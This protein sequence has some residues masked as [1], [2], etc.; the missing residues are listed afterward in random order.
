MTFTSAHVTISLD[1]FMAGPDQTLDDPLGR[2]GEALQV[3]GL[4]RGD[5]I[6]GGQL[7]DR[8]GPRPPVER[9]GPG[10]GRHAG[11]LCPAGRAAYAVVPRAR[12]RRSESSVLRRSDNSV[13]PIGSLVHVRPVTNGDYGDFDASG[14]G[15]V[16]TPDA[17]PGINGAQVATGADGRVRV[18]LQLPGA[19]TSVYLHA[20]SDVGTA[21]GSAVIA[22]QQ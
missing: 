8:I 9:G 1:G 4:Q 20:F 18:T 17:A 5:L 10:V 3:L 12:R 15:T 21:D 2:G 16:T 13:A 7:G 22:V 14:I 11:I 19:P 6:R